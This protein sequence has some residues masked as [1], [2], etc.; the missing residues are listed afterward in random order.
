MKYAAVRVDDL[1]D[2][3]L[4]AILLQ[5]EHNTTLD[6]NYVNNVVDENRMEDKMKGST[7]FFPEQLFSFFKPKTVKLTNDEYA[8]TFRMPVKVD[9]RQFGPKVFFSN[10]RTF[11]TWLN[12]SVTISSISALVLAFGG[13]NRFSEFFGILLL[14]ISIIFCSY[15]LFMFYKRSRML[16]GRSNAAYFDDRVGPIALALLLAGTIA[17]A[18]TMRLISFISGE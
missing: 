6:E 15:S 4:G 5:Q 18:F 14:I 10:E 17:T 11:L 7:S 2:N 1:D 16:R 9:A 12:I 3:N 13:D 8:D